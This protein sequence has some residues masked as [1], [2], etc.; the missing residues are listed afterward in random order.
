MGM[1]LV[2]ARRSLRTVLAGCAGLLILLGIHADVGA[3]TIL[4]FG[5]NGVTSTISATNN[6]AGQT[7]V[8]GTNVAITITGYAAGGTPIQAFL[9]LTAT[10]SG[11]AT[12]SGGE[13]RQDF[14]GTFSINS[15]ANNTGTN[16][17]SG[18]FS[19]A[20]FGS[21]SSLTLSASDGS[22]GESV[23]FTSSVLSSNILGFPRAISLSFSNVTPAVS[24]FN[25]SLA[26]FTASVGGNFSANV[27]P[28]PSALAIWSVLGGLGSVL[29][30]RRFRRNK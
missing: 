24:I 19:D 22:P 12:T 4:A 6:G 17:L 7:T 21:G 5:Q 9:D 23:T 29:G 30:L 14:T 18:T 2:G 20:I 3:A 8:T 13:F 15:L 28:E 1:A 16:F 27:V 25:G 26:G 10:S 11:V